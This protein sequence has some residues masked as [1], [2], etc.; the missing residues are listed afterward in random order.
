M[1]SEGL[2]VSRKRED[3]NDP[4]GKFK[5]YY[6]YREP[7]AK[8]PSHRMLAIRRGA[9]ENVLYFQI[10]LDAP[11]PVA[12]LKSKV[13]K[14]PGD[15]T[16]H[17]ELAVE[18]AWKRLLDMSIQTET[19]LEL[20]ERSDTEA[21]RVFRENLQNLLLSP[22]AGM[23]GVLGLD[24]GLRTGCKIAVVDETGKLLDHGVIYPLE[25]KND[26]AGSAKTLLSFI[27]KYNVRA[28]ATGNGTGSREA[29]GF[30]QDF[31]REAKLDRVFGVVVNESGASIYSASEMARQEFPD[32]DLTVRG[33]ISIARRLQDPLAELVKIDPKSI[34]VGQYQHDVDQRK[35]NQA[36]SGSEQCQWA[37]LRDRIRTTN[38]QSFRGQP[39]SATGRFAATLRLSY[40]P[41][42]PHFAGADEPRPN[43]YCAARAACRQLLPCIAESGQF[44]ASLMPTISLGNWRAHRGW[45]NSSSA[46][47]YLPGGL[48]QK[49][50]STGMI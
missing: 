17:L 1:M 49:E 20:K 9:E 30:V 13:L 26:K 24:P 39:G 34:G 27:H 3:A 29:S 8:I 44:P 48:H 47:Y 11:K 28:I 25:P 10:E 36:R 6:D 7:A 5:T 18:D 19:R 2:V 16:P 12:Y 42:H 37:W 35:L 45:R 43:L 40:A 50:A 41:V 32:L 15:W 21:I 38:Q 22:P 31:L 4:D 46:G 33:A 14:Q 23:I